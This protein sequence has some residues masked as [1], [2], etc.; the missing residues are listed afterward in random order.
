MRARILHESRG[1]MRVHMAIGTMTVAQADTF[2]LYLIGHSFVRDV[3]VYER[4]ADAVIFYD[5]KEADARSRVIRMLS[6]FDPDTCEKEAPAHSPR[7][8][9]HEYTD[10]IAFQIARFVCE[11]L[12]LPAW[13][14]DILTAIRAVP[15]IYEGIKSLAKLRLE[16]PVLDASSISAS[17]AKGDYNTA[18]AVMFMLGI[19]DTMDEW[20]HKKSI[21][22]LAGIMALDVEKAWVLSGDGQEILVPVGEIQAKDTIIIR[23]GNMIPLDGIVKKGDAMVNQSSLTGEGIPVHKSDGGFVYAGT[24]IE[25]G[26]L[27]VEV[28]SESGNGRYD[29]IVKMIE[30]SERLKSEAETK[31]SNLA[32][33]LVPWT[34]AATA[35]T[36]LFTRD[37]TRAT[38]ILM[39]DFCCALKLSMP[40]AVLSAMREA[41]KYHIS[42]KG[43]KF[44]EE[45]SRADTIIFDKT[46]TLTYARPTVKDVVPFGDNDKREML[47]L[48]ACLEEHYPH[49]IAN[50]VVEEAKKQG[51]D[52]EEHHTK[53]D[54]VV[55]HGIASS[56]DGEKVCIGSRHFIFDDE[57][58]TIPEG[59]EEKYNTLPEEYSH[60]Y[61]SI[62]GRLCAVI[63]IEDPVKAE[64][65]EV[66]SKLHDAGFEKIVM[67]TGDS[68]RT[69]KVVCEATGID[70]FMAEVLP[71]DK[72]SFISQEHAKGRK[73]I[74]IGDG[75]NDSPALSEA[76]VG[77]AMNSGAAIARE[78]ADITFTSDDLMALV[79]LRKLSEALMGR[80]KRNYRFIVSFNSFLIFMGMMGVF[81][82]TTALLH[83]ASTIGIGLN[84]MTDLI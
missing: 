80:I 51:L 21:N 60:L 67:M 29:R 66:V 74:M 28:S 9:Q 48:A 59:E 34:F 32:D 39:V 16:V 38:S 3:K 40:V 22:D 41:G 18:S 75:V 6:E 76:D 54:Y 17:I 35:L 11:K 62:G 30:D 14:R 15:Y 1:R 70:E 2:E 58:C 36:W 46:G 43:G 26:E 81:P 55:A 73:C 45:F 78:I 24:V 23:T 82:S 5:R 44:L 71:E 63:L 83:N 65:K 12:F 57:S 37:M 53:V 42:V 4:T 19:G 10:R 33:R 8:L 72:A 79:T 31:A 77:V 49:S 25:E 27:F 7:A 52:H 61:L 84:S 69:A 64:A 56:I 20:T 68:E 47:R 50:A 13:I